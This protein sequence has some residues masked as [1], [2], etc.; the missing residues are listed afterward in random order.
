MMKRELTQ[1]DSGIN[2]MNIAYWFALLKTLEN[3]AS[4]AVSPLSLN[5]QN[6]LPWNN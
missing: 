2:A 3:A 6:H 1:E 4:V 5:K